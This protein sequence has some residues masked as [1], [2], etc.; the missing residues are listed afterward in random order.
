[1]KKQASS[2]FQ[3][4]RGWVTPLKKSTDPG[5]ETTVD[6]KRSGDWT[7]DGGRCVSCPTAIE[8]G[9]ACTLALRLT[10]RQ[11]I[12]RDSHATDVDTAGRLSKQ[13]KVKRLA[14]G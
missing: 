6:M 4:R 2:T 9:V 14:R 11:L 13:L 5:S 1:M 12:P 3:T 8:G 10:D 7:G